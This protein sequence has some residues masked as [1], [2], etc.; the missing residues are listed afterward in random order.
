MEDIFR[1]IR[2]NPKINFEYTKVSEKSDIINVLH[3]LR[4]S[5]ESVILI[6]KG[7]KRKFL[8]EMMRI[9]EKEDYSRFFFQ[10][11]VRTCPL[12]HDLVPRHRLA[13]KE[14]LKHLEERKISISSL[15]QIKMEDIIVRWYGWRHGII[16]IERNEEIYYRRI[17]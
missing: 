2:E 12:K 7:D 3:L 10:S 13:T 8:P 9:V 15:P 16:A 17:K 5:D 4:E 11:E 14:E 1:E 6:I